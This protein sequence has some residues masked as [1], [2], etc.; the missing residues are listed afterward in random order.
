MADGGEGAPGGWRTAVALTA[1][2]IFLSAFHALPLVALP[3]AV[4]LVALPNERRWRTVGVA[5]VVWIVAV[6]LSGSPLGAVSRGW[7][8]LLGS[9]FLFASVWRPSWRVLPRA[10][11]ALA[12]SFGVGAV[13]LGLTGS[14]PEIDRMVREHALEVTTLTVQGM[15]A[16]ARQTL[17][18][19]QAPTAA[20]TMAKVQWSLFPGMLALQSLAALG[21]ASWWTARIGRRDDRRFQLRPLREFRFN[22]QLVWV[23]IAGLVLVVVS[24]G[25]LATR[26]GYNA[27]FVMG[28]LYALRG[29]GVF[30]FLA[31]GAASPIGIVFGVL[32]A[33]F[34]YPLVLT[35]A[36]LVGLGDTWLDL[37]RRAALA[38]RA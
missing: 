9:A 3:L 10:L 6:G 1:A 18:G 28:A 14:W 21:L 32:V 26:I 8:L 38:P 27:L 17:F 7:S 37:R 30:A 22:D 11:L 33:I 23:L 20:E 16:E 13:G 25:E 36:L 5:M 15:S 31:G 24:V 12:L 29:F 4:L 19:D 35:A 34:L 2:V